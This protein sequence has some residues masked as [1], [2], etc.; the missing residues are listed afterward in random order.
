MNQI[1]ELTDEAKCERCH[2]G[3]VTHK[4]KSD[5]LDISICADCALES[6]QYKGPLGRL[7]VTPIGR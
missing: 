4:A 5:I 6:N 3:A 7:Y 1:I 2:E